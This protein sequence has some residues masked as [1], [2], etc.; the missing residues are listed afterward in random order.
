RWPTANWS[1]ARLAETISFNQ[2]AVALPHRQSLLGNQLA[3]ESDRA[4]RGYVP[5]QNAH[6][7]PVAAALL[8]K[9]PTISRYPF[10]PVRRSRVASRRNPL[11]KGPKTGFDRDPAQTHPIYRRSVAHVE[12]ELRL[13][14][15]RLVILNRG[16]VRDAGGRHRND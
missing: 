1:R 3:L 9:G 8:G 6:K 10:A 11:N 5:R 12:A 15:R 16:R 4:A 7:G 13:F 14:W 2:Y